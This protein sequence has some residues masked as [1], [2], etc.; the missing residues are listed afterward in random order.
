[1]FDET[2]SYLKHLGI[3]EGDLHELPTSKKRFPDGG[4]FKIEVSTVNTLEAA[5]IIC[6]FVN[7]KNS[8]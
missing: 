1:M 3:P 2:R 6:S 4:H 5:E 8:D 7:R